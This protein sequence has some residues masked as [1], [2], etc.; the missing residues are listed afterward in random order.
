VQQSFGFFFHCSGNGVVHRDIKAHNILADEQCRL[1]LCDFG[2][3]RSLTYLCSPAGA[4]AP[5]A[6][7]P[8]YMAPELLRPPSSSSSHQSPFSFATDVYAFG[9]LV[10]EIS[11]G[12][13]PFDGF[14]VQQVRRN[15]C[16][17][18]LNCI[19]LPLHR[20]TMCNWYVEIFYLRR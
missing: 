19:A 16:L 8:P 2:L 13:P 9:V 20:N 18:E 14:D 12:E 11:G 4:N 7:T 3:A 15:L 5:V 10:N 6:G 17:S 1:K